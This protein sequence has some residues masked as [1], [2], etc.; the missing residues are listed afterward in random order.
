MTSH[1]PPRE[2]VFDYESITLC[3]QIRDAEGVDEIIDKLYRLKPLMPKRSEMSGAR[4]AAEESSNSEG[5]K[6]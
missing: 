6:S 2:I 3:L 1:L 5:V 4:S